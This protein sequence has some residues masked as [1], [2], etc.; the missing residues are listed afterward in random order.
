MSC[1]WPS[2]Q[3]PC[4]W[5]EMCWRAIGSLFEVYDRECA[6]ISGTKETASGQ[7]ELLQR[8]FADLRFQHHALRYAKEEESAAATRHDVTE[9]ARWPQ[10]WSCRASGW[11][12]GIT[13]FLSLCFYVVVTHS[14]IR[15]CGYIS[16][17]QI[18][19]TMCHIYCSPQSVERSTESCFKRTSTK[20]KAPPPPALTSGAPP[21]DAAQHRSV[22][23]WLENVRCVL[24]RK[25]SKNALAFVNFSRGFWVK[26]CF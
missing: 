2:L 13:A 4:Y 20:R 5:S 25:N 8:P 18:F 3:R 6:G 1:D 24:N 22:T 21:D 11:Q 7:H 16:R 14:V 9:H 15:E 26:N 17:R 23:G 12:P 19:G 10:P